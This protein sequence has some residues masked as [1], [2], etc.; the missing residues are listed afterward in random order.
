MV[1]IN[2][3]YYKHLLN[4]PC[5]IQLDGTTAVTLPAIP[6]LLLR[7]QK[8]RD[9]SPY[10]H[11][12]EKDLTVKKLRTS[13]ISQYFMRTLFCCCSCGQ[14][15]SYE[16]RTN[17][18]LDK[19]GEVI[20]SMPDS[21][22]RKAYKRAVDN[23]RRN[24]SRTSSTEA[25]SKKEREFQFVV[26]PTPNLMEDAPDLVNFVPTSA[27]APAVKSDAP[28]PRSFASVYPLPPLTSAGVEQAVSTATLSLVPP[29]S[30]NLTILVQPQPGSSN[31]TAIR[32]G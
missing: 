19:L 13:R 29:V 14:K 25:R 21:G 26:Q 5:V 10:S 16:E 11:Y 8:L 9:A 32:E 28:V 18:V 27:P 22:M 20:H 15:N 17:E 24:F 3:E 30:S 1:K 2:C 6:E 4:N 31:L 7:L 12:I 23:F